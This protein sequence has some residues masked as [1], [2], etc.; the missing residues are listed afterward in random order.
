MLS[1]LLLLISLF[2]TII[3]IFVMIL[4]AENWIL[5]P[6]QWLVGTPFNDLRIPGLL[7]FL[8][9]GMTNFWGFWNVWNEH[10]RQFD[11]AMLGGYTL[12][13]WVT[14]ELLLSRE[15]YLIHVTNLFLGS[16]L[17]LLAY[18]QKDKWAL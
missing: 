8:S 6:Q 15:L 10:P 1:L 4:P 14:V 3:G 18:Q 12:I 5:W 9:V 13:G 2:T 11:R 7:F 17:V 16:L